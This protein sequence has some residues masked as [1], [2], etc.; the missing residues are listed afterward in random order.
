VLF[1]LT[2]ISV[3]LILVP[4]LIGSFLKVFQQKGISF[5]F[6]LTLFS[7]FIEIFNLIL[8]FTGNNNLFLQDIYTPVEF[9]LFAL[10][11]KSFFDTFS[12]SPL[13]YALIGAF[14]CVAIFDSFFVNDI[15]TINNFSDSLEAIVFILYSLTAFFF[16]MKR[17][18][19]EDLLSTPFF[20]INIAILI[21]FAGNLF[22]FM[23]SN[24]LQNN[25]RGQYQ[26]LYTIHSVTNIIYY[27]L[28]SIGFW[29]TARK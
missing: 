10:F 15:F 26:A 2:Y 3:F 16:I 14:L 24:Y 27:I 18:M 9:V 1:Y 7:F 29:R 6:F 11:Y 8:A 19:F 25:D 12:K 13:H 17:L 20:W 4:L 21:Y 22:L 28:I 5:V 23:F